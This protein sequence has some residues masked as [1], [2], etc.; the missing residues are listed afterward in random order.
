[1]VLSFT[2]ATSTKV[3]GKGA[4][5]VAVAVKAVSFWA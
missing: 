4:A 5:I 2:N 1:M 3:A